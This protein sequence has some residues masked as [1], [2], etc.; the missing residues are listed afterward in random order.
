[1]AKKET[2]KFYCDICKVEGSPDWDNAESHVTHP[3]PL[4]W[5]S[6]TMRQDDGYLYEGDTC[7]KCHTE[8]MNVIS[9]RFMED[10]D[11]NGH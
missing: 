8:I 4:G 2:L 11:V 5:A 1:M 3:L 9:K 7:D 10:G 6:I